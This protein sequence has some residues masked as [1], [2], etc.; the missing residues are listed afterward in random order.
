MNST[1]KHKQSINKTS[2]SENPNSGTIHS[3]EQ[4][5]KIRIVRCKIT[6]LKQQTQYK[7]SIKQETIDKPTYKRNTNRIKE[8]FEKKGQNHTSRRKPRKMVKNP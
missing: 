7:T 8:I 2:K 3:D 1:G 4:M 6:K 5:W